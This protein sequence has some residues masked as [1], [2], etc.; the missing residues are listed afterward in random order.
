VFLSFRIG[1]ADGITLQCRRASE[2]EF[3]TLADDNAS[4]VVDDRPKIQPLS[5]ELRIYRAV[6]HYDEGEIS[7]LSKEV[8]VVLP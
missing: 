6:L 5:P 1:L 8:R 3:L 4:P 7:Q 2:K